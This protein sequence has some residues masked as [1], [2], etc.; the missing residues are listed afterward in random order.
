MFDR[1]LIFRG[2]EYTTVLNMLLVLNILK[3]QNTSELHRVLSMPEY[4]CI[5]RKQTNS[6]FKNTNETFCLFLRMLLLS[7]SHKL[8]DHK[9]YWETSRIL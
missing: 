5:E 6:I 7:G 3:V 8:A 4:A 1:V 9:M 2:S